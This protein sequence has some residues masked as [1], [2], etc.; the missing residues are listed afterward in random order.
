M[1]SETQILIVQSVQ[2]P[3]VGLII[4]FS[5]SSSISNS[6]KEKDNSIKSKPK[7]GFRSKPLTFIALG[8]VFNF[9]Y[10]IINIISYNTGSSLFLSSTI[11]F[12]TILIF[13]ILTTYFF[14]LETATWVL[15]GSKF[16]KRKINHLVLSRNRWLLPIGLTLISIITI[17][18][19][20]SKTHIDFYLYN[21]FGYL[22][23]AYYVFKQITFPNE[24][25]KNISSNYFIGIGFLIWALLQLFSPI[26]KELNINSTLIQFIGFSIS[27][28]SK[29]LIFFGLYNFS[30]S[31]AKCA[32]LKQQ[33]QNDKLISLQNLINEI[34]NAKTTLEVATL[35]TKHLT[36]GTV[37]NYDYANF[38]EINYLKRRIIPKKS[39]TNTQQVKHVERWIAEDGIAF[40]NHDI[41][42]VTFRERKTI[43]VQGYF[44]NGEKID[45]YNELSPLKKE[46]F[47]TYNHQFLDRL[48]IPVLNLGYNKIDISINK[49][50]QPRV[51]A[52][53]EVGFHMSNKSLYKNDRISQD[54]EL[55]IYLDNCAQ[56]Y[57]RLI[58]NE[59]D[60][61]IDEIIKTCNIESKDDHF[62][63]LEMI[64]KSTGK[65]INADRGIIKIFSS[66]KIDPN[67]KSNIFY[68]NVSEKDKK[69]ISTII[70]NYIKRTKLKS[71]ELDPDSSIAG[72]KI[73]KSI[74]AKSFQVNRIQFNNN[75]DCLLLFFNY[76]SDSFNEVVQSIITKITGYILSTYSEKKFH[77]SV[78]DLVMPNNAVTDLETNIVPIIHLLETYFE[79]QY[80]SVW[81]KENSTHYLQKYASSTLK[82][83]L[84][85]FGKATLEIEDLGY[86]DDP[87]IV[88]LD[89]SEPNRENRH[90]WE[91]ARKNKIKA[92]L[93]KPL[94]D[95]NQNY[96]F[97]N[98]YFKDKITLVYED[99]NFLNLVSLKGLITIQINNLVTAFRDISD[100]FVRNDLKTTLKTI[101][102][103]AM[104]LLNADPVILFKSNNGTDVYFKDVTYSNNSNFKEDKIIKLF[105]SNGDQ[106]VELAELIIN[107]KTTF[108]NSHKE[109]NDYIRRQNKKHTKANFTEDFWTR[110]QIQSMAAIRLSNNIESKNKP[111]GVM[112]INFRNRILFNEEII[113]IIETFA[114]LASG[115]IYN[116]FVFE[117]NRLFLLKT[118]KMT[119]PLLGEYLAA[120]ALHDAH[121]IY[122][123]ICSMYFDLIKDIDKPNFK[124]KM[125]IIEIRGE[126]EKMSPPILDLY[127]KFDKLSSLYRPSETMQIKNVNLVDII[128]AQLD[129]LYN[130]IH[131]KHIHLVD[132][133][134]HHKL[135]I[136][137][138]EVH[139]GNAIFNILN[140]AC[141]AMQKRGT[142]EVK[143]EEL[144]NESIKISIIDDGKGISQDIYDFIT[145][146]YITD[147]PDGS[148]LGLAM[149][150]LS[151]ENHRGHLKYT[152]KN[153]KTT[154]VILLPSKFN[155]NND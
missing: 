147:K 46:I 125:S 123:A 76:N 15:N 44:M 45:I 132:S 26:G 130:E 47:L 51:V 16:F 42:A 30:T 13:D 40:N 93:H 137:C 148:G 29:I 122:K 38:S 48:F 10:L 11:K 116:G 95:Q 121:K 113:R 112:F 131:A 88:F 110:E 87:K 140:N 2:L 7:V 20:F 85:N 4:I 152:S 5:I 139:I 154:F 3:V 59:I 71:E 63:Y 98:I 99:I 117:R 62:A 34:S 49:K 21:F 35:V 66:N 144:A 104:E 19:N 134:S 43:H 86:N 72:K 106:H 89:T 136:D 70:S 128:Q 135:F 67:V 50:K 107:G 28:L 61:E 18:H 58:D 22:F 153:Q 145:E 155:N 102:D 80:I 31:L 37:F 133:F 79:T 108:F 1:L 124:N 118:I 90:F 32:I 53:I 120:G 92:L 54:G 91:Y 75:L 114:A 14:F 52:I 141:Q 41:I 68:Y 129:N 142:L 100:S 101:T 105:N 25:L 109:Y 81:I 96:G 111:V 60:N 115:S 57:E 17:F 64:L 27:T 69:H 77:H 8:F 97:I 24:E 9:C 65:F 36:E 83:S 143:I 150:K 127:D 33:K 84:K 23:V 39:R 73:L 151:I 74:N 149:S 56:S 146:P 78:A 94:K 12:S 6:I 55:N 119:K 126:L 138:D 82:N 103:K